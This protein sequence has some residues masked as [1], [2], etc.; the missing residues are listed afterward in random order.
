MMVK[1]LLSQAGIDL[2]EAMATIKRAAD[3]LQLA[4]QRLGRL[5]EQNA[6]LLAA[7]RDMQHGLPLTGGSGARPNGRDSEIELSRGDRGEVA[8]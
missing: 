4:E 5:E 7:M 1:T 3:A 2:G 6:A 8:P